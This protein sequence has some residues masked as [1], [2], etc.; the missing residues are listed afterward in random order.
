V[1]AECSGTQFFQAGLIIGAFYAYLNLSRPLN[2]V[3][4][5]GAFLAMSLLG[6]WIRVYALVFLGK[7]TELQHFLVGW[8]LFAVLMAV[9]FW[10]GSRLQRREEKLRR[11]APDAG[12][13][14]QQSVPASFSTGG[15]IGVAA[16]AAL[17]VL[18]GPV[19]ARRLMTGDMNTNAGTALAPIAVQEPWLGPFPP[20]NDWQPSFQHAGS[21]VSAAYR[22]AEG[23]EPAE[24]TVYQA[25][26]GRQKQGVEV[27]NELNKVYDPVHWRP[28]GGYAG[29]DYRDLLVP[30][31]PALRLIETRLEDVRTGAQRLVWHWYRIGG[32]DVVRPWRAK[33]AQAK[34]LLG[35]RPD[36]MVVVVS[37]PVENLA[38]ARTLL[39]D[40]VVAN[41]PA[42]SGQSSRQ[43]RHE[44]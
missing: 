29:T 1:L 3:L 11:L 26:Y 7:L 10:L 41:L 34:G 12:T 33:V 36:A 4:A 38:V 2:R 32:Q 16:L 44:P 24:V 27:I 19:G 6:N 23:I 30:G 25:Y 13:R 39:S 40:F 9:V 28:R 5:I 42:L 15:V 43:V 35:G 22:I 37:T 20:G 31:G 18:A 14:A 17:L 8:G 21:H